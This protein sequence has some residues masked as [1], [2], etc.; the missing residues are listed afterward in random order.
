[1]LFLLR[2]LVIL[3]PFLTRVDLS[4]FILVL[5][6]VAALC[7]LAFQHPLCGAQA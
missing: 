2:L 7:L 3:L 4:D 6:V 1:M 5:I